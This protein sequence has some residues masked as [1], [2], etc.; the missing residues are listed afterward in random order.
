MAKSFSIQF[1][2]KKGLVVLLQRFQKDIADPTDVYF[3]YRLLLE[4]TPEPRGWQNWCN[5][6]QHGMSLETLTS[7]FLTSAEYRAKHDAELRLALVQ[8]EHFQIYVD[9]LDNS[10]GKPV[11]QSKSYEPHLTSFLLR[12]LRPEMNFL[13]IGANIGWFTLLAASRLT[14]GRVMAVEPN[15]YNVQL[16]NHSLLANQF[17]HVTVYP[18]AATDAA[19]ILSLAFIGSN[20]RIDTAHGSHA[21]QQYVQG[22]P[23][24]QLLPENTRIDV[25]KIDIEGYEWVAFKG[26][27]Q[28]LRRNRPLIVSE[29]HP[30]A[31]QEYTGYTPEDYLQTLYDLDYELGVLEE[32]GQVRALPDKGAIMAYWRAKNS[33]QGLKGEMH[34]DLVARPRTT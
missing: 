8:A 7:S 9:S 5:R 23:L 2:L 19:A 29:F 15:I 26:M 24:D 28:L 18:F 17:N 32:D 34:L 14:Q 31:M 6:I 25:I 27:S 22:L 16:L 13:D 12:E 33:Q 1:W 20:G 21:N 10:V 4:R 30:K 11:M 3:S